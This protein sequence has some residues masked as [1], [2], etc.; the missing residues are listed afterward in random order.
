MKREETRNKER[1][2]EIQGHH[3]VIDSLFSQAN[4]TWSRTS[5][6]QGNHDIQWPEVSEKGL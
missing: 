6:W 3:S 1:K 2:K 4:R 5:A